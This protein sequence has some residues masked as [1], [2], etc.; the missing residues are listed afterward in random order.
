MTVHIFKGSSEF[1]KGETTLYSRAESLHIKAWDG[2]RF[3]L[4][5][6]QKEPQAH[7][8]LRLP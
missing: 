5:K 2:E 4:S 3:Y 8:I 7:W 6:E 1:P